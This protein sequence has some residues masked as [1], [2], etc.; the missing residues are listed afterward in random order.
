MREEGS[1]NAGEDKP[2]RVLVSVDAISSRDEEESGDEDRA[3]AIITLVYSDANGR[4]ID[5]EELHVSPDPGSI[6][7]KPSQTILS[8]PGVRTVRASLAR[9]PRTPVDIRVHL[10]PP[11][12]LQD[13]R[14]GEPG[15]PDRF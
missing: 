11:A 4:V 9:S 5:S 12:Y 10:L 8:W 2:R 15:H 13:L 1:V 3:E 6:W 14:A 7:I